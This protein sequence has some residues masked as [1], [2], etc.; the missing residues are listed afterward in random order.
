MQRLTEGTGSN[1]LVFEFPDEW[2]VLK[3][4]NS[5]F[6]K[7]KVLKCQGTKAVDFLVIDDDRQLWIEVKNFRNYAEENRLRLDSNINNVPGLTETLAHIIDNE[8]EKTVAVSRKKLFIADEIALKVRDTCAGVFGAA[9]QGDIELQD[10]ATALQAHQAI[11]VVLFLQQDESLDN[12]DDFRRMA[13]R[14]GDKIRQQLIFINA[15]VEVVNRNTLSAN[16]QWRVV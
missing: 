8:W 15:T 4:D 2:K 13:Q 10:F 3:Y 9:I 7:E 11:H 14:I 16:A 5:E 1:A 6:Y 12:R